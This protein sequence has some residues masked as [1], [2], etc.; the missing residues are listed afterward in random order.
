MHFQYPVR[1]SKPEAVTD[2]AAP[3]GEVQHPDTMTLDGQTW[4]LMMRHAVRI[5][6]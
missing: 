6:A 2:A 3:K 4:N 5:E 1:G